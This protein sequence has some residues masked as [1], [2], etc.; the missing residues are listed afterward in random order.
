MTVSFPLVASG[1]YSLALGDTQYEM[2]GVGEL[3][4]EKLGSLLELK[5]HTVND[6][7]VQLGGI[8][9]IRDAFVGFQ[10]YLSDE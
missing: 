8:P 4:Q 9:A 6:A 5:Y 1:L 2:Q 10:A 7:A 3:D